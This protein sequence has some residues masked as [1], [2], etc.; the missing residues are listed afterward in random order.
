MKSLFS[1]FLFFCLILTSAIAYGQPKTQMDWAFIVDGYND[2]DFADMVVD[3]EGNTYVGINYS[4]GLTVPELKKKFPYG[5]HVSRMLM[6]IDK[7][8]KAIW[9]YPMESAYDGR[10]QAMALAPNGDVL[11]T[12]FCDGVSTYSSKGDTIK[13]GYDKKKEDYHQP[14]F[15]FITR[16]SPDGRCKWARIYGGVWGE[17]KSV[18]VNQRGEIYWSFYYKGVLKDGDKV[19]DSVPRKSKI[20]DKPVIVKLDS[21]GSFQKFFPLKSCNSKLLFD[22]HDNLILYGG[23]PKRLDFTEKDSLVINNPYEQSSDA[24]IAKYDSTDTYLWSVKIGGRYTQ[25]IEDIALDSAGNIYATGSYAFECIVSNGI[26]LISDSRYEWKSG[27]SF[28]YC[29]FTSDGKLDFIKYHKQKSYSGSCMGRTLAIDKYGFTHI[30]GVFSD[31]LNFHS[32]AKPI[33]GTLNETSSFTSIW[34]KD[35]LISFQRDIACTYWSSLRKMRVSDDRVVI[36]GIYYGATKLVTPKGRSFPF[37]NKDYGRCSFICGAALPIEKR[38]LQRDAEKTT[39]HLAD[40]QPLMQC[41]SQEKELEPS[42][43][44]PTTPKSIEDTAY[45]ITNVPCGLNIK[46]CEAR[47][48]PNPAQNNVTLELTGLVGFALIEIISDKGQLLFSEN[49]NVMEKQSTLNFELSSMAAGLYFV[50]VRQ[51]NFEKV[52]RLIKS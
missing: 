13:V 27:D 7:K 33:F 12:G 23:M 8:G 26:Q 48:Y 18:A 32:A 35:S 49:I 31:S 1:K 19:L 40:L 34:Y 6:K 50:R 47:L 42:V 52:L 5:K 43:W 37:T 15:L 29:M 36:A 16:Y 24:F 39:D 14:T 46:D 44:F 3:Q 22:K 2:T 38:P 10:I 51:R 4:M 30:G 41:I 21:N 25:Q 45:Q 28:F 11:I 20:D 9:G 17:A